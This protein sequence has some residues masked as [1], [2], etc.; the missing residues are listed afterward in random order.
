MTPEIIAEEIS[1]AFRLCCARKRTTPQKLAQ[2]VN[3]DIAIIDRIFSADFDECFALRQFYE[4]QNSIHRRLCD[5]IGLT[6][7]QCRYLDSGLIF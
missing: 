7:Q 6:P 3:C 4:T 5:V 1:R 2:V